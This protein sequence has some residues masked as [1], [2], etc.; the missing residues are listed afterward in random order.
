VRRRKLFFNYDYLDL[1]IIN[2][3][4]LFYDSDKK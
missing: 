2:K 4:T 3:I 1:E